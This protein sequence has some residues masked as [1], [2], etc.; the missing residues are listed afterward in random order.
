MTAVRSPTPLVLSCCLALALGACATAPP[1][2]TGKEV[3]NVYPGTRATVTCPGGGQ[4]TDRLKDQRTVEFVCPNGEKPIV[5][6]VST[7]QENADAGPP[8]P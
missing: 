3:I 7:P 8:A 2:A 4:P 1:A 6:V 5:K